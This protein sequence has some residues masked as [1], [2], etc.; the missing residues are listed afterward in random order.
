MIK[1]KKDKDKIKEG[2]DLIKDAI[3]EKG[4]TIKKEITIKGE[5]QFDFSLECRK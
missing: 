4:F 1:M 5:N 3:K 2:M